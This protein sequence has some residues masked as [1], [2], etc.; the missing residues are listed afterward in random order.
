MEH[1]RYD[2]LCR[3]SHSEA[4]LLSDGEEPVARIELHFTTSVVYGLLIVEREMREEEILDLIE[5]IDEDLVWSA[6]VPRDD[7]VV[8]VYQG[9]EV[10]VY[11]DPHYGEEETNGAHE[12]D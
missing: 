7:F 9:K 1:L 6:D 11:S 4:Y 5:R 2:R 12:P 3:T 10:G 8:T